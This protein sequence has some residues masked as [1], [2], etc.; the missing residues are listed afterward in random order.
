MLGPGKDE[1]PV[2]GWEVGPGK[3]ECPVRGWEVVPAAGSGSPES[4][5]PGVL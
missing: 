3:D 1:C 2:R 5:W 4:T